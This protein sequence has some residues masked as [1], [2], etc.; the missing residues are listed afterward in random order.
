MIMVLEAPAD[1]VSGEVFNIGNDA[2]NFTKKMI[3]E[4]IQG[5]LPDALRAGHARPA[6]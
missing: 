5:H 6:L 2:E 4:L 3:V 1:V